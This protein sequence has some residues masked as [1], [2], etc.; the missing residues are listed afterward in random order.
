MV[1]GTRTEE[2]SQ[3]SPQSWMTTLAE[4]APVREPTDSIIPS[5]S[6]PSVTSPCAGA[7]HAGARMSD[8]QEGAAGERA[9]AHKDHVLPVEE[10]RGHGRDEELRAV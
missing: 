1:C 2:T 8:E 3:S 5:T 4:V 10:G 6:K 9:G 7:V